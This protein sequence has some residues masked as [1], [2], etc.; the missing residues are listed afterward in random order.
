V[1][2]VFMGTSAFALPALQTIHTSFHQIVL[3]ITQ[4]DKPKGRGLR[5]S[6]PPVKE[7][8]LSL[9][10]PV[11]QPQ[12]IKDPY[13]IHY[14]Q[15]L[16]PQLISAIAYGQLLPKE[17][18]SLPEYGCV[19][20]HPSLLPKYRGPAPIPW[21]I[22]EGEDVTGVTTMLM[23]EGMDD[24]PIFLQKKIKIE[25]MDTAAT[26][27]DKLAIIGAEL[28]LETIEGLEKEKVIPIPQCEE[29]ASYTA[30]MKKE[31]GWIDWSKAAYY[32]HNQ[33]RAMN[34]WPGA[35]SFY[36]EDLLKIWQTQ[37]CSGEKKIMGKEPGEI[38]GITG[39]GIEVQTGDKL[40]LIKEIQR[41]GGQRMPIK[42]YLKGYAFCPGNKLT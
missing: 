12:K 19:N 22:L 1:Q 11:I 15:T 41:A 30:K 34:P 13:V 2:I 42:E 4:P 6:P 9:G 28:L 16:K 21:A 38:V 27:H 8:A 31:D 37:I 17:I 5:M 20:L 14:L 10:L 35:Y 32:I 29:V 7:L 25:R 40:L 3:V 33:V 26:L 23:G 39:E 18:L 24:G 36:G